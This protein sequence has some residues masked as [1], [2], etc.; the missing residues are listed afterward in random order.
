[1][2]E[3]LDWNGICSNIIMHLFPD[4]SVTVY[5]NMLGLL[6]ILISANMFSS[7]DSHFR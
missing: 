7:L 1:M 5:M 6:W 2:P 4:Y 3:G